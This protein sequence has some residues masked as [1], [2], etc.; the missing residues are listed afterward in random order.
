MI[1]RENFED[2]VLLLDKVVEKSSISEQLRAFRNLD[3]KKLSKEINLEVGERISSSTL[4]DYRIIYLKMFD[5]PFKASIKKLDTLSKFVGY[6]DWNNF[7]ELGSEA[8]YLQVELEIP[9][10]LT[11]DQVKELIEKTVINLDD[12]HR[13]FGGKGLRVKD[14]ELTTTEIHS[15]VL[16]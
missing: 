12:N 15:K 14:I 16:S 5:T 13:Y 1:E 6:L 2:F 8:K 3:L 9:G 4:R 11:D 10:N 7:L